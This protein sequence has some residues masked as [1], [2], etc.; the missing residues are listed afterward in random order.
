MRTAIECPELLD[1]AARFTRQSAE[2]LCVISENEIRSCRPYHRAWTTLRLIGAISGARTDSEFFLQQYGRVAKLKPNAKVLIVGT[3]DHAILHMLLSA[4]R[5]AGGE[6]EVSI[7]DLCPTTLALNEWYAGQLGAK[8]RTYQGDL[9][10][11]DRIPEAQDLITTH[12]VFSFVPVSEF[13]TVF[14]S[15]KTKLAAGGK[16]IFAQGMSPDLLTGSRIRFSAED[17]I[18]FQEKASRC[19]SKLGALPDLDDATV[20]ALARDFA[21]HKD[22]GAIG[23]GEDILN[24]LVKAGFQLGYVQEFDRSSRTYQSSAPKPNERSV[25]LRLVASA[26]SGIRRTL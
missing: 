26:G 8:I 4:F 24:P 5:A 11:V 13:E 14:I 12:S 18:R 10:A 19:L 21:A 1:D 17:S 3:A 23:C 20:R 2:D 22:L 16:L 7:I 15:F 6:P 9:R 25:S